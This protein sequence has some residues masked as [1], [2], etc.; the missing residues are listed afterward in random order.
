MICIIIFANFAFVFK[1]S[2]ILVTVIKF[3]SSVLFIVSRV[4]ISFFPKVQPKCKP[5]I[6]I[7]QD[8]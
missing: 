1:I 7:T 2:P 5:Q 6:I 8:F 3:K 4:F